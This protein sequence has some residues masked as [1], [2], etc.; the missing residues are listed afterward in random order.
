MNTD[1]TKRIALIG[2]S[3]LTAVLAGCSIQNKT[4]QEKAAE[5]AD[6]LTYTKDRHGVCYATIGSISY[7][8]NVVTSITAVPCEKVGL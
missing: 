3:M 4:S 6:K 2:A 5:I 1:K 8:A 7:A